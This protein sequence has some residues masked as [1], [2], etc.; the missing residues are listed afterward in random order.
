[1]KYFFRKLSFLVLKYHS[2]RISSLPN[3]ILNFY[4][5]IL[6][7]LFLTLMYIWLRY[8]II[9]IWILYVDILIILYI[10]FLRT[11][12]IC[13]FTL[14]IT[15]SSMRTAT[16]ITEFISTST[17]HVTTSMVFLY[18]KFTFRALFV[19]C[20]FSKLNKFFVFLR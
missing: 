9:I 7:W 4:L 3:Y 17:S 2:V 8:V 16:N 10:L 11:I 6:W 18:P 19:F 5:I 20:T 1:M 15:S 13:I 12:I 14:A